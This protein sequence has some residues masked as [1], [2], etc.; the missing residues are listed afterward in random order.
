M[1]FDLYHQYIT[2]RLN[3]ELIL[4]SLDKIGHFHVAGYPGR[5]EP[6]IHSEIDYPLILRALSEAGFDQTVGLEYFPQEDAAQGLSALMQ[7]L[8]QF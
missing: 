7:T 2:E 8:K 1:L 5:H 4:N 6:L 3:I